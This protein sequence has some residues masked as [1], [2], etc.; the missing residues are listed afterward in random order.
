MPN[1]SY[2]QRAIDLAIL[3]KG[4]TAPN[5][6]VGAVIVKNDVIIGEG[7]HKMIGGLH[8]EREAIASL[9][10]SCEGA[11]LYV[12]LEPCCHFGKQPPC[13][14]AIIDNRIKRVII[15]SRDPNPLVAGNGVRMLRNAGVEVIEDF[16]R[17]ECDALNPIFFHYITTG[18]PYT[19]LKFAET[20]DGKIAAFTGKSKWITNEESRRHVHALRG[21]YSA[22]LAGI[23]TVLAD[24]PLLNCRLENAHQ[25][26]RIVV[27]SHLKLPLT[28]KL[29]KTANEYRTL[30]V[31]ADADESK[32]RALENIGVSAVRFCGEDGRVDLLALAKYLGDN[33]ISSVLIEGGG[34]INEAALKSGIV[35][36]VYAY[37]APKLLGGSAAKTPVE[38]QGFAS[39]NEAVK[40]TLKKTTVFGDDVLLEYDVRSDLYVHRDN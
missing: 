33:S 11:D 7:W 18:M 25:P 22:V 38:G 4:F 14:Q 39:P 21:E 27:D 15:G 3:G 34:E 29:C 23:G 40:M 10:E 36:H 20:A 19:A 12:T 6:L 8:A 17:E 30:A 28:S 5:P 32:V 35:N 31:Y 9:N 13:T 2:M 26:L 37:I 24:D 1:R 16:M